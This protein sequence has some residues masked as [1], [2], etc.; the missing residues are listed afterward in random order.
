MTTVAKKRRPRGGSA[1]GLFDESKQKAQAII[2]ESEIAR[3]RKTDVLRALR[4]AR[5]E[6]TSVNSSD[7]ALAQQQTGPGHP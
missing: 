2:E 4:L 5:S 7:N 6:G 3:R 1:Y